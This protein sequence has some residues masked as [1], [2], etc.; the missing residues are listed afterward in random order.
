[1]VPIKALAE[2]QHRSNALSLGLQDQ[3]LALEREKQALSVNHDSVVE[4]LQQHVQSN[5]ASHVELFS[6]TSAQMMDKYQQLKLERDDL[7]VR[8]KAGHSKVENLT[9]QHHADLEHI[10]VYSQI[11]S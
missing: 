2:E 10:Q 3:I 7:Q 8:V 5:Y 11:Y 6:Q 4:K 1:M 9:K